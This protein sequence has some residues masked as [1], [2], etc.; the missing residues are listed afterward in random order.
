MRRAPSRIPSLGSGGLRRVLLPLFTLDQEGRPRV[1]CDPLYLARVLEAVRDD[2]R[3]TTP[4]REAAGKAVAFLAQGGDPRDRSFLIL[5]DV[6]DRE[7][8]VM[9]EEEPLR[10]GLSRESLAAPDGR[11]YRPIPLVLYLEHLRS[12]FNTGNILRSAAA[13]GVAGVVLGAGCP[14]LDHPRLL[15]AAMGSEGMIPCL[16]GTEEDARTLL[17][18]RF[19]APGQERPRLYALE[20]GGTP[21]SRAGVTFPAVVILGHEEKGVSAPLL[22]RTRLSGGIV[23]IPH[24][25]PKGSLNVGVAAGILLNHLNHLAG[26]TDSAGPE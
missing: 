23:T 7:A 18:E 14:S 6:L 19:P 22:E 9:V 2:S 24:Q 17:E 1:L 3:R 20:T 15:R 5:R 10:E 4:L 16:V 25:G 21:L 12:P 26:P 11:E 13:F 8:G